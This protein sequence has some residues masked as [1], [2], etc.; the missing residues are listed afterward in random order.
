MSFYVTLSIFHMSFIM[1]SIYNFPDFFFT[2]SLVLWVIV[3]NRQKLHQQ[4]CWIP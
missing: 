3:V 1:V 4:L 2:L